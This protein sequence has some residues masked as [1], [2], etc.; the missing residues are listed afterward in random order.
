MVKPTFS[1][2]TDELNVNLSLSPVLNQAT[3]SPFEALSLASILN[4][5]FSGALSI[6]SCSSNSIL[7]VL[8]FGEGGTSLELED[9][10]ELDEADE[11]IEDDELIDE[12]SKDDVVE[13]EDDELDVGIEET[14]DPHP[15]MVKPIKTNNNFF[16]ILFPFCYTCIIYHFYII[17]TT[18]KKYIKRA[19]FNCSLNFINNEL[20]ASPYSNNKLCV[21]Q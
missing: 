9:D 14:P 12:L 3:H 10:D 2:A 8:G 17:H 21:C 4:S 5:S 11:D 18:Y 16:F 20:F 1:S 19:T 15:I 7:N 6:I 13:L